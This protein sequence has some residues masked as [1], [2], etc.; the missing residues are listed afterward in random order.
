MSLEEYNERLEE[1]GLNIYQYIVDNCETCSEEMPSLIERLRNVDTSGQ[2]FAS[3]AKYLAAVN[4]DKFEP[5]LAPLIEGA[6][7]KDRERRYI[8]SLLVAIWG[9]D[10]EKKVESLK[11]SDDNF[12]KIF[13]RLHPEHYVM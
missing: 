11:E 2:F 12:R 7:E 1:E 9:N 8:G 6:I 13:K 10:Y 4:R 3:S 5:W